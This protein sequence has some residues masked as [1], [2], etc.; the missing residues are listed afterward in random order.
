M[1]SGARLVCCT[2]CSKTASSTLGCVVRLDSVNPCYPAI[3]FIQSRPIPY[4]VR[5]FGQ[6]RR[7]IH[8]T[9]WSRRLFGTR[10]GRREAPCTN[11]T[12]P[13]RDSVA[14]YL[15]SLL[16]TFCQHTRPSSIITA[17]HRSMGGSV[18][19]ILRE[20][21]YHIPLQKPTNC[22]RPSMMSLS[23][24]PSQSQYPAVPPPSKHRRS[25]Y[26][27]SPSPRASSHDRSAV[28]TPMLQ[29]TGGEQ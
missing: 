26:G 2:A 1:Q 20:R 13:A 10:S 15:C 4:A 22:V 5:D 12:E 27:R 6:I 7:W 25:P 17:H 16:R 23:Q 28:S 8:S 18:R 24:P 14:D 11:G 19:Y 29:S 21:H 3:Q 9:R